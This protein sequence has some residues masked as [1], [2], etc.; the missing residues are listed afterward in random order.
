[1]IQSTRRHLRLL[2]ISFLLFLTQGRTETFFPEYR[3]VWLSRDVLVL[4]R[5]SIRNAFIDLK[6]AGFNAVFVN[7]WYK[8][9]TIYPSQVLADYGGTTQLAEFEGWDPLQ[10]AIQEG[11][12]IGLEIHLWFEYG[13]W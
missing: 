1:M 10:V 9:S 12:Q 8:G 11:H 13:L 4:G 5:E 2:F 7:N 6:N 3:T